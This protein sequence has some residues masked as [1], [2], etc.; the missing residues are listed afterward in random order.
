MMM[1]P[2]RRLSLV[3]TFLVLT[4]LVLTSLVPPFRTDA[5]EPPVSTE[6]FTEA[7]DVEV[8]NVEVFVA[9]KKGVPVTGLSAEDF[10]ILV[11]GKTVPISNFYAAA[12]GRSVAGPAAE[13]PY[14]GAEDGGIVYPVLQRHSPPRQ[15]LY[16]AVVVDNTHIR[17]TNRKRVFEKLRGFLDSRLRKDDLVTVISLNPTLVVHSDFLPDRAAVT[18]MLHDVERAADRPRGM[19]MERNQIMSRLSTTGRE[20]DRS[21]Y[22]R[23]VNFD[24]PDLLVR[25]RA[26][27]ESEYI[28][29]LATLK[30][31]GQV[32]RSLGGVEG[33]KALLYVSDGIANRPG[34][35][36]F[37]AWADRFGDGSLTI[38]QGMR[39]ASFNT[40]YF[41]EIGQ[42]DLLRQVEEVGRQASAARVT[43]YSLD[44][45]SD[46]GGT[47]KSAGLAGGVSPEALDV[48]EVNVRE[49]LELAAELTGGRRIQASTRFAD[50]LL[51]IG[52]DFDTYYSLGFAPAAKSEK[53]EHRIRVKVRGKGLVVR[54]R[55]SW[56]SKSI[57]ELSAEKTTA[58]L[59]YHAV[60]NPLAVELEAGTPQRRADGSFVVPVE[61]RIPLGN[62]LL[63][64]RGEVHT[65]QLSLYVTTKDR[66][67]QSRRVQKLP[68]N[69]AIPTE[70]VEEARGQVL[71]YTLPMILRPGDQQLALGVRD[72][73]GST[74]SYV[75]LELTS[76]NLGDIP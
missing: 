32:V 55:E 43:W 63:V 70:K 31:L 27:A 4:S 7:V 51:T 16:I 19:E 36:M 69:A 28:R 34:E 64:P 33:R 40:D 76:L 6:T 41:R 49:P 15:R 42:F 29:N 47:L 11:D 44:A 1:P 8:V 67:G 52:T 59:L 57:D 61:I 17:A 30:T 38:S 23:G 50:D 53:K 62:L 75:R 18:S 66:S 74:E 35:E 14:A 48:F 60:S 46:R 56:Q 12:G 21:T 3:L 20:Y 9:D 37:V 26:W 25:I 39:N 10:E 72:N 22:Q 54:H 71:S 45:E 73:F 5:Q 58:A 2:R 68:F 65:A 24:S 13:L